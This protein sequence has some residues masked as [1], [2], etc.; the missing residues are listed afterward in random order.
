MGLLG[1]KGILRGPDA[2]S[3]NQH[4]QVH[5]LRELISLDLW[6]YSLPERRCQGY[7][8]ML[9]NYHSPGLKRWWYHPQREGEWEYE[10]V[11]CWYLLWCAFFLHPIRLCLG[12]QQSR[13][14][15]EG[16]KDIPALDPLWVKEGGYRSIYNYFHW[17][18]ADATVETIYKGRREPQ[19][20]KD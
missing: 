10:F 19:M 11:R 18:C 8:L 15:G 3:L 13:G 14:R 5:S 1:V 12:F 7:I 16:I 4:V 2:P 17:G 9:A 6:S 20:E